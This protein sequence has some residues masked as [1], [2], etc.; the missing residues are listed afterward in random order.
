M[1]NVA[2]A[3]VEELTAAF[4]KVGV[5]LPSH[6]KL[7]GSMLDAEYS[8]VQAATSVERQTW[9]F[10]AFASD[11]WKKQVAA[12]G[13]PMINIMLL[14]PEAVCSFTAS[15][16]QLVLPRTTISQQ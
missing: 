2:M 11:G 4:S 16:P 14:G 8:R 3:L 1:R 5:A 15:D 12:G 10:Y 7:R 9:T 6:K 13:V